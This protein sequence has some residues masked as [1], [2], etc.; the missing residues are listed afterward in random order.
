MWRRFVI[1]GGLRRPLLRAV[2]AS[3]RAP[4]FVIIIKYN[5]AFQSFS[6]PRGFGFAARGSHWLSRVFVL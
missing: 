2:C 4:F 3:A 6:S 1:G 5:I